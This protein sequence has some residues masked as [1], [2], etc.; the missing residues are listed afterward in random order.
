MIDIQILNSIDEVD[1]R[2]WNALITD[3]NPFSRHEFLSALETNHCV[4][5]KFGWIPRHIAILESKQLIGGAILYEKYNNYGEFVFD[6]A[7][8]NA[9]ERH[10]LAYYPKLVSAIPY[11]PASGNRILYQKN[12]EKLVF[13]A[14]FDAIC[15]ICEKSKISSWHCLFANHNEQEL[16]KTYG[17]SERI[18][19]QFHWNNQNYDNFDD[20]LAN[21]RKKKRKNIRQERKRL[22]QS[23]IKIRQLDGNSATQTD[24]QNFANFYQQTFLEKSGTPT[25]NLN[26][27]QQIAKTMPDQVLLFL[28]DLDGDCIA[29]SL[30]FKSD[31]RLYGRHWGCIEQVDFLHFELC[32]YQGIEYAIK[33]KLQVFEPGAQGEHKVSRGFI[34][35]QTQSLHFIQDSGFKKPID[36]FCKMEQSHIKA[37]M[38]DVNQHN[39][40]LT[41]S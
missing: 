22:M 32:Y 17:L 31:T 5:E 38:S 25:L 14:V 10:G 8:Y 39:P 2:Q 36:D 21:L 12:H 16:L 4:G 26:F 6:H 24:W 15:K 27:F 1:A 13:S 33:H 30:M 37:Y 34:P 19:C 11:T 29:G 9:Y 20:F 41:K 18:D 7:W 28:A 23:D 35:T 40:Y 3:N